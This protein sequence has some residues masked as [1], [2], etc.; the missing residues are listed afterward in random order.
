MILTNAFIS[1][2]K[3]LCEWCSCSFCLNGLS[4]LL[5]LGQLTQDT[6]SYTLDVL[7]GRVQQLV[8]VKT[9]LRFLQQ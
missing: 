6:C 3:Q 9:Q 7:N 8:G 4:C 1:R 2:V 5:I